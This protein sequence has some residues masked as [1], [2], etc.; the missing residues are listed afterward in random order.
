MGSSW[1]HRKLRR[2]ETTVLVLRAVLDSFF[3]FFFFDAFAQQVAVWGCQQ[4]GQT[5]KYEAKVGSKQA[6]T[7]AGAHGLL[8]PLVSAVAL[9]QAAE[10]LW[11]AGQT[12]SWKGGA[13]S[14]S[15]PW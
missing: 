9:C 12:G 11:P 10:V 4:D 8:L 2:T 5:S 7:A 6:R 13:S 3:F 1:P 14:P 15:L